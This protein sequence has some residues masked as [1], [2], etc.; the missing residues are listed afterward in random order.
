[1]EDSKPWYKQ[2]WPWFLIALPATA[3]VAGIATV[4]IAMNN[5]VDLVSDETTKL[6][7]L[8]TR[9]TRQDDTAREMGLR[10]TVHIVPRTG[11]VAVEVSTLPDEIILRLIH[12]TL[13]AKD[14]QIRL[15]RESDGLYRGQLQ[16]VASGKWQLQVTDVAGNWRLVAHYNGSDET[17][18]LLPK[19][20]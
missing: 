19:A 18:E 13:A 2:F 16:P 15:A 10:A 8:V 17:V 6:G 20:R 11:T 7:K 4:I 14:Q 5:R 1:M 12:A 9:E 3:V